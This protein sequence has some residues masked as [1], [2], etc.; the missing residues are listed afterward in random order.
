MRI[1]AAISGGRD[2]RVDSV[3][4]AVLLARAALSTPF[5]WVP[6][7]RARPLG[8]AV[9]SHSRDPSTRTQGSG[10]GGG[11]VRR[12]SWSSENRAVGCS[13]SDSRP[14]TSRAPRRATLPHFL[15]WLGSGSSS[16]GRWK[17]ARSRNPGFAVG[18]R[19]LELPLPRAPRGYR[20]P[21][22]RDWPPRDDGPGREDAPVRGGRLEPVPSRSP[23]YA[24]RAGRP[25]PPVRAA[26]PVPVG[27]A[28][29]RGRSGW[30]ERSGR[31]ERPALSGRADRWVG[32]P[33]DDVPAVRD[34]LA[35]P[36][37]RGGLDAVERWPEEDPPE[38]EEPE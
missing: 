1:S 27:R 11:A 6:A 14:V 31:S 9:S 5:G 4:R 25:V 20:S 18:R 10:R 38:P 19:S 3:E 32:R 8:R 26:P 23:R 24:G 28:G 29:R 35:G 22:D 33:D 34:P 7:E 17:G 30:S 15:A 16:P 2:L 36:D 21:S 12:R 37:A 13:P